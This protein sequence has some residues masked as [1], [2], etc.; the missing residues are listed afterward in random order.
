MIQESASSQSPVPTLLKSMQKIMQSPLE[1]AANWM[2]LA[3]A[4]NKDVVQPDGTLDDLR[5]VIFPLGSFVTEQ[6]ATA[7]AMKI[8]E[9]TGHPYI[10]VVHYGQPAPI[11]TKPADAIT[12]AVDLKGKI[13]DMEK[14]EFNEQKKLYE[15][16][17]KAEQEL[18]LEV[19]NELDNNHWEHFK[20]AVFLALQNY[21]D[22]LRSQKQ[23]ENFLIK[24]KQHRV[25]LNAHY[26]QYPEHEKEFL[27]RLKNK[28]ISRGEEQ[29]YTWIE[30]AY[31]VYRS[32]LLD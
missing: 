20:R 6:A 19:D 2:V 3:Y 9:E 24:Y 26:Q 15:D 1:L 21:T 10:K 7:H 4:I 16:R 8:M 14:Q 31:E 17:Q 29:L 32:Q 23:M 18:M 5:A 27:P 12:V 28:L 13:I 25:I 11:T 30:S 22:Y